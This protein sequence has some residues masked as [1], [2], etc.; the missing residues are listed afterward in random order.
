MSQIVGNSDGVPLFLEELTKTV[1][2][3]GDGSSRAAK[4]PVP[5][6]LSDSF[7][8]RL[9]QLGS[10][11]NV[12]RIASVLGREFP[13]TL[14]AAISGLTEEELQ[15]SLDRLIDAEVFYVRGTGQ[16]RTYIFKHALLQNA[17]YD[18]L[19]KKPR[20]ALHKEEFPEM[21]ARQP[22]VVAGHFTEAA[23]GEQSIGYWHKAGM[24]ALQRSAHMEALSHFEHGQEV[25]RALPRER[26]N[27]E[28]ELLLLSGLGPALLAT[29]G[30]GAAEVGEVYQRAEK[31]LP[32]ESNS[33]LVLPTLWGVW[34]YNLVRSR[35][36]HALET[37]L[38]LIE[39]GRRMREDS[40]A[41]EG[42]WTAGNTLYWMGDL[43]AAR[44]YLEEAEALYDP[45]RFG[46]H[47]Y[48]FGQDPL[49]A[50][51]CYESFVYCFLGLFDKATA[52][53]DRAI[54]VPGR[55]V[56]LSASDWH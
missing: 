18:S 10:A 23:L 12:A 1:A 25:F 13:Q 38:R 4:L 53:G 45:A 31:L 50:T 11:R 51:F 15:A 26:A 32:R 42:L 37:T 19:L 21:A 3:S 20:L 24:S 44:R 17:A 16:R 5:G 14:L 48:L 7:I 34:V 40:L 52:A 33:P 27:S 43:V 2:E 49:V 30:F 55:C 22:K 41:L 54:E 47:A 8:A 46:Q 6:S 39:A 29:R 56:I 9:D 28:Q 36:E 35:L